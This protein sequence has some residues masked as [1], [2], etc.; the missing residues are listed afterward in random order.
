[1]LAIRAQTRAHTHTLHTHAC[2]CVCRYLICQQVVEPGLWC[3]AITSLLCPLYN[4]LLIYKFKL[5][6]DGAAIAYVL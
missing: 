5:G 3:T 2:V 1:M 6:L 4:W